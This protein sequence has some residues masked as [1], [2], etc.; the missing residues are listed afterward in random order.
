MW[1]NHFTANRDIDLNTWDAWLL[2]VN[3]LKK[4]NCVSSHTAHKVNN[5]AVTLRVLRIGVPSSDSKHT[6]NV[7]IRT[8]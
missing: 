4:A 6:H 2:T 5:I 3:S 8:T 1:K 7:C